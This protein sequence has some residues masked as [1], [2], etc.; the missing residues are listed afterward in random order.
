M[1]ARVI[2]KMACW[3]PQPMQET[4]LNFR[5]LA[6]LQALSGHDYFQVHLWGRLI[7]KR[8]IDIGIHCAY[9]ESQLIT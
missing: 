1:T 6:A 9:R 7:E 3:S 4:M 2:A 5:A 8:P